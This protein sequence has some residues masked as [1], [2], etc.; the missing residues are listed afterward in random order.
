MLTRPR[1]RRVR[2]AQ[3][4]VTHADVL[5]AHDAV[6]AF[7][8]GRSIE[9]HR[10]CFLAVPHASWSELTSR[11]A[12]VAPP[13]VPVSRLVECAQ[14]RARHSVEADAL[15]AEREEITHLDSTVRAA[16]RVRISSHLISSHLITR[17]RVTPLARRCPSPRPAE[18]VAGLCRPTWW[19]RRACARGRDAQRL[20]K[21]EL[22][23]IVE[24][25]WLKHWREYCWEGTRSDP[26]GPVCNWRLLAGKNPRANLVRAIDYRGVN[27]AVWR[28]RALRMPHTRPN[29]RAS[30]CLGRA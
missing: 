19:L 3:G 14:C 24:A 21:G 20:G 13:A 8:E 5:C 26:P 23:F 12:Q 11:F 6:D 30:D 1:S 16:A 17:A 4:P 7:R 28:V 29:A 22:W 15:K 2:C 25:S 10:Q 9:A 27:Y 18:G